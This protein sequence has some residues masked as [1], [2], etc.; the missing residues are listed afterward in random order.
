MKTIK[1]LR[2]LTETAADYKK[3]KDDDDEVKDIKPRSKG[4][5]DFKKSHKIDKKKHPVAKDDQFDGSR[6]GPKGEAGEDHDGA[7]EKGEPIVKQG[8]SDP[9]S[10]PDGSKSADTSKAARKRVGD[11]NA[12]KQGSS[13][14]TEAVM[15][16]VIAIAKK[17]SAARV[18]FS[19]GKTEMVDAY[20]ASAISQVYEKVNSTN[21][22]KMEKMVET[23]PGFMKMVDF[24]MSKVTGGGSK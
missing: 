7:S 3:D 22:K 11:L 23:L 1:E 13:K 5:D 6:K 4:E 20:T 12:V 17:H 10:S 21:K 19:N 14:V 8:S 18:K 9:K 2:N 24:A 15:K 16:D